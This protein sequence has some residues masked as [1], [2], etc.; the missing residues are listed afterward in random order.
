MIFARACLYKTRDGRDA[1][2]MNTQSSRK[3]PM[4]DQEDFWRSM[5]RPTLIGRFLFLLLNVALFVVGSIHAC[6]NYLVKIFANRRAGLS[7]AKVPE[8]ETMEEEKTDSDE[9]PADSS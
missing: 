6:F 3:T 5:P 8:G 7:S 9:S 1:L 2:R 4:N